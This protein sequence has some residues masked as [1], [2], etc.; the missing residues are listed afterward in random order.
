MAYH[1]FRGGPFTN[2]ASGNFKVDG[3]GKTFRTNVY[4]RYDRNVDE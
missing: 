2:W 1:F 3:Q 4:V